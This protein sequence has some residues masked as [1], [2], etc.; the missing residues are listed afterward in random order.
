MSTKPQRN[1]AEFEKTESNKVIVKYEDGKVNLAKNIDV[2]SNGLRFTSADSEIRMTNEWDSSTSA[3]DAFE[4]KCVYSEDR[5]S[6]KSAMACGGVG[7]EYL[8]IND[9]VNS[10]IGF[11][12]DFDNDNSLILHSVKSANGN[13]DEVKL[14]H[15]DLKALYNLI[16]NS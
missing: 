3:I 12:C 2:S 15:E 16:H 14:T 6:W 7:V 9:R 1:D 8:N 11:L 5:E 4:I 13:R 10:N